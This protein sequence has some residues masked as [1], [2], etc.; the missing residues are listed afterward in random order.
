[1]KLIEISND[2]GSIVLRKQFVRIFL[3][4]LIATAVLSNGYK[5]ATSGS[6]ENVVQ[7]GVYRPEKFGAK[8]DGIN[9]DT[10]AIQACIDKVAS[11]PADSKGHRG[12][13]LLE[14]VY[15]VT[16]QEQVQDDTSYENIK[17][18]KG[19]WLKPTDVGPH[20]R[21]FY[22]PSG[23]TIAGGGKVT[24]LKNGKSPKDPPTDHIYMFWI[25]TFF[26]HHIPP[27]QRPPGWEDA[28]KSV[29]IR[30][31]TIENDPVNLITKYKIGSENA[32][33]AISHSVDI[34]ID[35]VT[36]LN[37]YRGMKIVETIRSRFKN[38]TVVDTRYIGIAVYAP[39]RH[40]RPSIDPYLDE[41]KIVI[42]SNKFIGKTRLAGGI[43]ANQA[44]HVRNNIMNYSHGICAEAFEHANIEG[45]R[46]RRSPYAIR[47]GYVASGGIKN[48]EVKNNR[49]ENCAGGIMV[50]N[51]NDIVVANNVLKNFIELGGDPG[52]EPSEGK[53]SV[54]GKSGFWGYGRARVGINIIDSTNVKVIGNTIEGITTG[55]PVGI[56]AVNSVI[57]MDMNEDPYAVNDKRDPPGQ[58]WN[59]NIVI[60]DNK[61]TAM[62]GLHI[63]Y[64]LEN[65]KNYTFENNEASGE[66]SNRFISSTGKIG[67]NKLDRPPGVV[68]NATSSCKRLV[69]NTHPM[70]WSAKPRGK[71]RYTS[72]PP[73]YNE[74]FPPIP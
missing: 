32:G 1:M 27:E 26:S 35:N 3:I 9:D 49:I 70:H 46:I 37:W 13:V 62:S 57:T 14:N 12:T 68:E 55:T 16:R 40:A 53:S 24:L 11:L 61:V 4:L 2:H 6:E 8:G 66:L 28:G 65:Q 42:E 47:A 19:G 7:D 51:A 58:D 5:P 71:W 72:P 44:T 29:V 69:M 59:S 22:V 45:N 74:Y 48:A 25:G 43:Y 54:P 38:C 50:G 39:T 63:G 10:L 73:D 56:R 33:L 15:H 23:V 60:K 52:I 30:G 18:P 17:Y 20:W 36:L 34:L 21:V 31:I 67:A 41:N 64:Y